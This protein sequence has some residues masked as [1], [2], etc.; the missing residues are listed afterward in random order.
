MRRG[1]AELLPCDQK[2]IDRQRFSR[3]SIAMLN[4]S[5]RS[6]QAPRSIASHTPRSPFPRRALTLRRFES[7]CAATRSAAI[8]R[9][10]NLR[11]GGL[12]WMALWLVEIHRQRR[13]LRRGVHAQ[14]RRAA[15]RALGMR[16]NHQRR[17]EVVRNSYRLLESVKVL[18]DRTLP[19]TTLYHAYLY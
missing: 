9:G 15:A 5:T 19:P 1:H 18:K 12:R 17:D 3:H 6:G 11:E 13:Q 7:R 2:D 14:R 4:P 16:P 8:R 10:T